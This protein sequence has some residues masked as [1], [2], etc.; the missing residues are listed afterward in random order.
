[1]TDPPTSAAPARRG[2]LTRLGVLA[3]AVAVGVAL[4]RLLAAHLQSI[5]DLSRTDML[6]ARA[7]LARLFE[8]ASV[9]VFGLTGALGVGIVLSSRRSLALLQFPPPGAW[10]W[11]SRRVVTGLPARKMAL[12]GV[13][14]GVTLV[15]ASA[16]GGGLLW[17]MA[18]VL[19][20]CRAGVPVGH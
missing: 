10:S 4:Q 1:M 17:Y 2:L 7:E 16:A 9:C 15:L 8:L 5:Q 12:A 11:G 3:G 13:G 18:T 19:R 14:L 20:A 6:A